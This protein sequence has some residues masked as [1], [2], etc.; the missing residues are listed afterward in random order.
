MLRAPIGLALVA[1]GLALGAFGSSACTGMVANDDA[2]V[3]GQGGVAGVGPVGGQGGQT[4]GGSAGVPGG[5]APGL[6]GG[7]VSG[8][9]GRPDAGS[10]DAGPSS[11]GARPGTGGAPGVGGRGAGG[12]TGAG[13]TTGTLPPIT[14]WIAGDSTVATGSAPCPI[15]WGGLFK[16]FFNPQVAVT[17]SAIAGRSVR[18]W[19]YFPT[20]DMDAS[21]ECILARDANGNPTVQPRWQAMLDGMDGM[22]TGDYLLI[23]FGI[24]DSSA[25]CDRHVGLDAFKTSYGVMAQA[26]KDRGAHPVFLTPTSSISCN[27]A[28]MAVGTRGGY[29]TATLQAGTQFGVPVIDLHALSVARYN[30]LRFCPVP[31]GDVSA[32]TTGPVGDYFCDDHTHF[33]PSGAVDIATLVADAVR[34]QIPGLAAYLK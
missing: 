10:G 17:N 24:N 9:A 6:G 11:D 34:T 8:D 23:Q 31:G 30:A 32:T 1:I 20:L 2:G 22:K 7:T 18:T 21:G 25:T 15:G 29:V 4:V 19:L 14:I 5:S 28:N 16:P 26:A 13:G 12:A 27:S 33:S 3:G